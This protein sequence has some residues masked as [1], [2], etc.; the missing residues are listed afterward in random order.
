MILGKMATLFF[1]LIDGIKSL[2]NISY[3][4]SH[5]INVDVDKANG[6]IMQLYE[7]YSFCLTEGDCIRDKNV[8][9][10]LDGL[11]VPPRL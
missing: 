1:S 6:I 10:W 3:I 2:N 11:K 7:K 5:Q 9:R 8:Q 4:I